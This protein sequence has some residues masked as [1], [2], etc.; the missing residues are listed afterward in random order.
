MSCVFSSAVRPAVILFRKAMCAG[1]GL[2]QGPTGGCQAD[3]E[4]LVIVGDHGALD[5]AL[6]LKT[7][8]AA[9]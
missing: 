4:R 1:G 8:E 2:D 9:R 7:A 5:Q 3:L 6:L